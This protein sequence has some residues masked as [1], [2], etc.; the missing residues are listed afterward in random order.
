MA[1]RADNPSFLRHQSAYLPQTSQRH[2]FL[3]LEAQVE[4][5]VHLTESLEVEEGR[6]I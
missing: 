6:I 1:H 4:Q 2:V 3:Q 5:D